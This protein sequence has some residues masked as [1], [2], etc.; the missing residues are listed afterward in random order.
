MG[1][2]IQKAK[3][4]RLSHFKCQQSDVY[5]WAKAATKPTYTASEVGLGN[6][7][8]E[9]KAT[10]FA[11]AA[12]TGTPTA[13]TAATATNT[14][15]IATTA[16]VK[17]QGYLTGITKAQI[18]AV[19]TGNIT[20]HT[21]SYLPLSGG[22]MSNTNLVTN[23]NADLLDGNHISDIYNYV[24]SRGENLITNGSGLLGTNYNFSSLL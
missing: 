1:I 23:L 9:S 21:H 6:V 17:A 16:F 13:P 14:T 18:E 8:N 2:L 4:Y 19:L 11:S 24:A 12:L 20:S 3:Y 7:T 15:Q 22:T 5:A 10:M